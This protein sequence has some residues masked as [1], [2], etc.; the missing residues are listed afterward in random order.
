MPAAGD[1]AISLGVWNVE[2]TLAQGPG[3]LATIRRSD[4]LTWQ[5]W[6]A[7]RPERNEISPGVRMEHVLFFDASGSR[8]WPPLVPSLLV[9]E[10]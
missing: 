4:G 2:R 5:A 8:I 3:W 6:L 10:G 9:G 1:G 7:E